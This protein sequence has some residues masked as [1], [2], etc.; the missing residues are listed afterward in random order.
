MGVLYVVVIRCVLLHRPGLLVLGKPLDRETQ[1]HYTLVVT[2]SD[3][4]P[5]G[6]R[7]LTSA[8]WCSAQ[9]DEASV[10]KLPHFAHQNDQTVSIV[11]GRINLLVC[12]FDIIFYS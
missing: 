5:S 2:A 10:T 4:R 3:G 1:D 12:V 9:G 7:A 8:A 6:V 11:I